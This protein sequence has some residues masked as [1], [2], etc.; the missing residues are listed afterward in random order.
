MKILPILGT[1]VLFACRAPDA[2]AASSASAEQPTLR[3][4]V[5]WTKVVATSNLSPS[6]Y[7]VTNPMMRPGSPIHGPVNKAVRD[8][9]AD[10]LRYMAYFLHPRLSI[11][12]LYPP[13]EGKTSWDFSTMDPLIL[14]FFKATEGHPAMLQMSTLPAWFFKTGRDFIYPDDPDRII[15]PIAAVHDVED[16]ADPSGKQLADYYARVASWYTKG[17]F[18]DELG[19]YHRSGHRFEISH[20]EVLNEPDMEYGMTP[21]SYTRIY[22]AVVS[23]VRKVTPNTKFVGLSMGESKPETVE[24]FL[25][26]RNHKPGIPIDVIGLHFYQMAAPTEGPQQWQYT[27]FSQVDSAV[28][29]IKYMDSIRKRL[30]PST[31]MTINETATLLPTDLQSVIAAVE[32]SPAAPGSIAAWADLPAQYWNLSGAAFA[33]SFMQFSGLGIDVLNMSQGVAYPGFYPGL[34][35]FNWNTGKPNARYWILKLLIDHFGPGEHIVKTELANVSAKL[36]V[37]FMINPSVVAKAY[38][39]DK[40]KK[41]LLINRRDKAVKVALPDEATGKTISTVDQ[42]TGEEPY[43]S[44]TLKSATIEMAPFAVSVVTLAN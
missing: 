27:F 40:S 38:K 3:V 29:T 20:W 6:V 22:D 19:K 14:D 35:M 2:C 44:S 15:H 1:I 30:S 26:A 17:G 10:Y 5:D 25:D 42:N 37:L 28:N 31:R 33:Y 41:L 34:S 11:A 24:Y 39:K 12:A 7:V 9:N 36:D 13:K 43:R 23:E 4:T 32:P 8:L 18:T 21:E 16:L